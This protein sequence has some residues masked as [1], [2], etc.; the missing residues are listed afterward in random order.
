MVVVVGR[1]RT[2]ADRRAELI[3]IGQ[4]VASASREEPGC[5]SYQLCQD[6]EDEDTFVFVEKWE[7]EEALEAHFGTSH[8]ATFMAAVPG[9]IVGAPEVK[10]HT[11]ARSRDL[12][13]VGPG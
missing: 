7:S 3:R 1:V 8:I 13:E 6:T 10:F 11:I 12:A 2:D 5:I 9:A 4:A